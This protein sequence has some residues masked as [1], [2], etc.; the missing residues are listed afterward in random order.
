MLI[1]LGLMTI[2]IIAGFAVRNFGKIVRAVE[3]LIN[4]AIFIL[5]FLLGVSVGANK[6]I[7][8]N[9]DT[10]GTQAIL[11]AFGAVF[12]SIVVAFFTYKFF[13]KPKE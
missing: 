13:F 2:G 8:N 11:L 9:L 10:L 7:I 5:L 12:G 6:T 1:V 4:A 3:P